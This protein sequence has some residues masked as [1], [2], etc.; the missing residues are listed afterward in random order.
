LSFQSEICSFIYNITDLTDIAPLS[1]LC[2]E[3]WRGRRWRPCMCHDGNAI[4]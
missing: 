2:E 4:T 3:E 1:D